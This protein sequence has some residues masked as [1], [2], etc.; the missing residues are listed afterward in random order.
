MKE[1]Y[2]YIYYTALCNDPVFTTHF[3]H[4]IAEYQYQLVELKLCLL[5]FFYVKV[6]TVLRIDNI[7]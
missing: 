2:A 4:T 1:F 6:K 7:F 5:I 3:F